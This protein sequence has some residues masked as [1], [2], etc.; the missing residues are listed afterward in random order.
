MK[1]KA[2]TFPMHMFLSPPGFCRHYFPIFGA[3]SDAFC[4]ILVLSDDEL[5]NYDAQ[6]T[7]ETVPQNGTWVL[8]SLLAINVTFLQ[9]P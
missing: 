9:P 2:L 5:Q 7:A 4:P 3:L 8:T 1:M 6:L